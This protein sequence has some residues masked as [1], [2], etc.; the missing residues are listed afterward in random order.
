MIMKPV[1]SEKTEAR[2]CQRGVSLVELIMF[3][4]IVSMS[5]AGILG[6]MNQVMGHSADPVVHKQAIAS[7]E[8]L[9]E[10]IELQD[11]FSQSGV[12]AAVT[13]ANR[14]T[15]YHIVTDYNNFSTTGIFPVSGAAAVSG[16]GGY[17]AIVSITGTALGSIAA[18]SAVLVTVTVSTPQGEQIPISGY[19]TA[20]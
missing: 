6:V 13:Q 12:T 15:A 14:A 11:F 9:L 18:G 1:P 7:A 19:R 4:V 2:K 17:N 8:S 20:Y 10:E 16:L 5:L 3:I